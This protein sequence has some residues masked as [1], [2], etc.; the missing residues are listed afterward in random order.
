MTAQQAE[1]LS[2][3]A[4]TLFLKY[5]HGN[6]GNHT[7]WASPV[8]SPASPQTLPPL[9]PCLPLIPS[10]PGVSSTLEDLFSVLAK[11]PGCRANLHGRFLPSAVQLL[12]RSE[13][14]LPLGLVPVSG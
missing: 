9:R 11:N 12:D 5:S 13:T 3:V 6:H 14:G 7:T 8:P 2:D 1:C 10:D 4:M